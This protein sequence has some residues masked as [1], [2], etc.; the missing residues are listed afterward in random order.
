M[1]HKATFVAGQSGTFPEPLLQRSERADPAGELDRYSPY[2]G[3]Q[4]H[5]GQ[6]GP[7]QHQKAAEDNEKDKEEVDQNDEISEHHL[8]RL[9][10]AHLTAY[11]GGKCSAAVCQES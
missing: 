10:A 3:R 5:I 6:P 9:P 11:T 7:A 8:Y 2:R 4:M 1:L